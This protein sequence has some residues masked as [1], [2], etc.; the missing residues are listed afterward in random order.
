MGIFNR[1]KPQPGPTVGGDLFTDGER[2]RVDALWRL[3]A[4]PREEFEATYGVMLGRFWRYVC[5]VK[6]DAWTALKSDALACAVAAL[7]V[8]QAHVLPRFAA[9]EDAARLTEAMSFALATAVVAER[10]G[11][12]VG[13]T[14]APGWCPLAA[15]VPACA[16]LTDVAVPCAYGALLLPRLT[17]DAGLEWL[18]QE[19][20]ALSALAAYFGAGPSELRGIAEEAERRIGLALARTPRSAES[21]AESEVPDG[22]AGTGAAKTADRPGRVG[23]EGA[24]WRWINWVRDGVRDGTIE[25]NAEGGWL[26]NIAG[27]AY[28]AVPDGFEAFAAVEG[29]EVKTVKNR[30]AR[31]GRHRE[32]GSRAGAANTFRAELADGRRVDGMVFPGELFWD[33]DPPPEAEGGLGRR[34]R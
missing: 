19:P 9:A 14:R 5:A 23:G 27:E 32:R 24:G 6:G 21:V 3:T 2:E 25:V 7:R 33:G 10:F 18:G 17:G 28:V 26:H 15:D 34:R 12:V 22:N 29:V 1:T 16:V 11:L 20:V 8:R 13:R 30:V 4:L 31:L